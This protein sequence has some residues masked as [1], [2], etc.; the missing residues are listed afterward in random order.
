MCLILDMLLGVED[1][2]S[3]I[4]DSKENISNVTDHKEN[5]KITDHNDYENS[6]SWLGGS[7]QITFHMKILARSLTRNIL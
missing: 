5:M 4:T 1:R 3:L 2:G 6:T 7:D